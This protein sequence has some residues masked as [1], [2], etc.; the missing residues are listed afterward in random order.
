MEKTRPATSKKTD[1]GGW[2]KRVLLFLISQNL[3]IF[4][5][6]VVGFS[7]IWYITL[8][9][10]SGAWI[11]IS[12]IAAL[13]PQI[14]VSLWGGVAAD[15]YSRKMIIMLSDGFT[16]LA[17]LAAFAAFH[18]GFESLPLLITVSCLR[19]VGGGFQS[20]AVNAIYPQIVPEEQLVRINGL[21]QTLN[22]VLL[23]I[24]PAAGGFILGTMGIKWAFLIDVTTAC[25]AIAIMAATRIERQFRKPAAAA[26][27]ISELREGVRYTL[28]NPLLKTIMIC[29]AVSFILIT[30]AAFLSPLMVART[31]GNEVWRLTANEMFWTAGS[32]AGGAYIAWKGDFHDKVSVIAVSLAGFGI[33]FALIGLSRIF[34]IFLALD[35]IA[36]VFLPFMITAQT[37][38]IQ[39]NTDEAYMG[40]VF[41]LLQFVSQG[42][43]PL[44]IL[45]FGP[46]GDRIEIQYIII[47][48]GVMQALWGL[49]FK[50][51]AER[52]KNAI[53]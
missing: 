15:R 49:W 24:S 1:D 10:S 7:I 53:V 20:P 11:T 18:L 12:T 26:G 14:F 51:A 33:I 52:A 47:V 2:K 37:V 34:W 35:C 41:S 44:A 45:C 32:L 21:N 4:G 3:S 28:D 22:N 6:S 16:A 43:M 29:Y 50:R 40:R 42:V 8:K 27:V 5:S 9:T 31:F 23:L 38:L 13:T 17:T 25:L 36:G 19:S 39:T 48:C 46:L 30:P